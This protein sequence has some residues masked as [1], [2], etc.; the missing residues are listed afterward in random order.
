MYIVIHNLYGLKDGRK[1]YYRKLGDRF[2]FVPDKQFA[3]DLTRQ[4]CEKIISNK[5]WYCKQYNASDMTV[6]MTTDEWKKQERSVTLTNEQWNAITTYVAI[7]KQFC[8]EAQEI[9][10]KQAKEGSMKNAEANAKFW[11]DIKEEMWMISQKILN[12]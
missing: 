12:S 4:E 7:T 10:E 8:D 1:A 3:T 6:R 2:D 11:K 5:D 9:W